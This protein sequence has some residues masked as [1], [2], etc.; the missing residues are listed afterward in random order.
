[1]DGSEVAGVVLAAGKGTRMASSL[2][3]V[4]H[5]L[6]GRPLVAYPLDAARAAGVARM[7]VVIGY[8][9]DAVRE[10]VE[11][12]PNRPASTSFAVQETQQGTGH[13]V[14]MALPD[15]ESYTGP[16]LI[17]SGD[18]PL[19]RPDTLRALVE[20]CRSSTAGLALATFE[21]PD[22]GHYGR[23]VRDS[24]GEIVS[25][26]EFADAREDER[27]IRECNAGV[28]CVDAQFLREQLPK[29]G[30]NNAQGEIYL[31]DLVA[32]AVGRVVGITVA[33]IEVAG[34]NTS[35]QLLALEHAFQKMH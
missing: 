1:M 29:L 9:A 14:L 22:P 33:P 25:I 18:V 26:R 13:A 16:V 12:L 19:I 2:P 4:L 23:I 3:K 34:V 35:E 11:G 7:V 21:P 28:Y 30:S 32:Q 8:Q 31:T 15:L 24:S 20:G 10:A 17:L 27:K 5:P 6:A